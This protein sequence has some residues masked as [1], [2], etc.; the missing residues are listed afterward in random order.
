MNKKKLFKKYSIDESHNK[1][2]SIDNWMSVEIYRIMHDGKLPPQDDS[3][4]DWICDFLDK[5]DDMEWWVENVMC[6]DDFGNLYLTA[7][8]MVY[9]LSDEI[10]KSHSRKK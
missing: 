8:R 9:T 1:W 3:S 2:E 5:Q 10:L 6:R 4:V 7:K